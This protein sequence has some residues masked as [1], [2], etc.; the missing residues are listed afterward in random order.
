MMDSRQREWVDFHAV[1]QAVT[2]E[3]VLAR[4]GV[5]LRRVFGNRLRGRCPLPTHLS[6]ES[7]QSFAVETKKN[8]WACQSN[9]CVEA[10]SG[11]IGGNVLDFVA[12]MENC[13][14]R[15]AA[16]KLRAWFAVPLGTRVRGPTESA[17][18]VTASEVMVPE[19]QRLG[20]AIGECDAKN[21]PLGFE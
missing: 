11:R 7:T 12:A 15:E 17:S 6:K 13:S 16:I 20:P 14:I 4:Y 8:A 1:K 10:R 3:M 5:V 9:S 21:K 18:I 19:A 2:M